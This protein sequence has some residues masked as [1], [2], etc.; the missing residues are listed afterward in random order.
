MQISQATL[1]DI[2]L[3][4][5]LR[6]D[7]LSELRTFTTTKRDFL[8][9]S[10]AQYYT[11]HLALGDFAAL[12]M[13]E[14]AA[15]VACAF[16]A[17]HDYPPTDLAPLSRRAYVSNVFTH[18]A[19]RRQGYAKCLLEELILFCRQSGACELRL[20]AT[21]EGTRLYES[22]GFFVPASTAMHLSVLPLQQETSL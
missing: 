3:L 9:S 5:Q 14:D 21:P 11:R 18:N 20:E 17:F 4:V 15:V 19:F 10:L 7:F 1:A 6:L 12:L 16:I 13:R 2:P 22:L 8:A